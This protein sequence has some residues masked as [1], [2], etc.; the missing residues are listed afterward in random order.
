MKK[1]IVLRVPWHRIAGIV[2]ILIFIVLISIRLNLFQKLIIEKPDAGSATIRSLP[3]R[4]SWM[5]IFQ[6]GRKIGYARRRFVNTDRGYNLSESVL[7]RINTMGTIQDIRF[8]TEGNLNR[9]LQLIDFNF[10]LR[11][12]LFSFCIR[13]LVDGRQL[14]LFIGDPG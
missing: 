5:D 3:T 13:G 12:S 14:T 4:D 6:K 7:M 10:N 11:S 1:N 2:S 9:N 8:N